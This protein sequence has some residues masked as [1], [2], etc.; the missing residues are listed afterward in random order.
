MP[1]MTEQE[2]KIYLK[3]PVEVVITR[4]CQ[5]KV[6]EESKIEQFEVGKTVKMTHQYADELISLQKAVVKGSPQHNAWIESEKKKAPKRNLLA[7]NEELADK[8]KKLEAEL[9]KKNKS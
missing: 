8:V 1:P 2:R 6:N 3:T 5:G 9:A 7:E 4:G